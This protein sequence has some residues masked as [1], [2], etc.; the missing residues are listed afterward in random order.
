MLSSVWDKYFGAKIKVEDFKKSMIYL[1]ILMLFIGSV[2]MIESDIDNYHYASSLAKFFKI[3]SPDFEFK[4]GRF[5]Y[6]GEMP[7]IFEEGQNIII[8]DTSG[9][10]TEE[11]LNKY[12]SGMFISTT[13]LVY[14]KD[15]TETKGINLIDYK[16]INFTRNELIKFINYFTIP[17]LLIITLIGLFFIYIFKLIG[18]F[19]LTIIALIINKILKAGIDYQNLFKISIYA[20]ALPT[21]IDS[22]LDI[23]KVEIPYFWIIYYCIATFYIFRYISKFSHTVDKE[24]LLTEDIDS[25]FVSDNNQPKTEILSE[26]VEND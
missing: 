12:K 23:F 10:V 19:I 26:E 1:L 11:S 20:I 6:F 13:R 5:Y 8:V 24:L 9:K 18:V 3:K 2:K 22:V 14:K 15:N 16:K 25:Q 21:V 7:F 4:N 17:I